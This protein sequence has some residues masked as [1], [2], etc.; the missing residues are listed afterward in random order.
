MSGRELG[1]NG[2]H[3]RGASAFTTSP[4]RVWLPRSANWSIGAWPAD[5]TEFTAWA[6]FSGS[7]ALQ[8]PPSHLPPHNIP[9]G[10]PRAPA[11]SILYPASDIDWHLL[12]SWPQSLSAVILEPPKIKSDTVCTV[13]P[14]ISH[15][16]MGPDAMIFVF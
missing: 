16:V 1:A 10:H 3:K 9:L 14:S 2:L 13:S 15:E 12:N 7:C 8:N 6:H 4:L 5:S 11:P